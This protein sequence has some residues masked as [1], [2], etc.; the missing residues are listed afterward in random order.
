[1]TIEEEFTKVK[2]CTCA[3]KTEG[4]KFIQSYR[5]ISVADA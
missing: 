5:Q 2:G 3:K 4:S 1:M